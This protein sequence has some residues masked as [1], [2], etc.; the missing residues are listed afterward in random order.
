MF[1]IR[2]FSIY[3][4]MLVV[5]ACSLLQA[6]HLHF[7]KT[8]RDSFEPTA[9]S[10]SLPLAAQRHGP[11][12]PALQRL[13]SREPRLSGRAFGETIEKPEGEVKI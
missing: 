4:S 12:L 7:E 5:Y 1:D 13:V 2:L 3:S 10:G 8:V 11:R 6:C 9:M